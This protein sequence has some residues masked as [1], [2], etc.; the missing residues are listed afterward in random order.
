MRAADPSAAIESLCLHPDDFE[1]QNGSGSAG[2]AYT[3]G[4]KLIKVC[5][6]TNADDALAACRAG[7]NL[8]GVIFAPKSKRC[9]TAEQASEVVQAVRNFGER[10]GQMVVSIPDNG[11]QPLPRLVASAR[12]LEDAA[13]RPLVVGVF[14]NQSPEFIQQM[15]AECGL[16]LVQLHGSEGMAAANV[17]KCHAPAIRVVD[18]ETDPGTGKAS[19]DAVETL[20]KSV[21]TDPLAILLDTSIKGS[22]EGGGTG[23]TFDWSIAQQLQDQGLPVIIAGGLSVDNIKDAV[24]TIRP[25]GVDVSSGVEASPGKKDLPKVEAF[26]K[27]ARDA[28]I[29]ASK[30]F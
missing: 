1:K 30:G 13:K 14:Q 16:D 25:W 21:T 22:K 23:V 27:N 11:D 20:L 18:I 29:E 28:A 3:A 8:I 26:V 2:G 9:V 10:S 6:I 24:G 12:A 19:K 5:G 4:T 17:A 7:A 15:V